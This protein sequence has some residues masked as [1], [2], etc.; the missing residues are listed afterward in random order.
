MIPVSGLISGVKLL[1][2]SPPLTNLSTEDRGSGGLRIRLPLKLSSEK[3]ALVA[4]SLFQQRDLASERLCLTIKPW[5]PPLNY[6]RL[7]YHSATL[8]WTLPDYAP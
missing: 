6:Q 8:V 4:E 3:F 7:K 2:V 5:K 1:L